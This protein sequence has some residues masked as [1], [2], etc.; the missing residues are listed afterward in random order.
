[1]ELWLNQL[2]LYEQFE[3]SLFTIA[4][5]IPSFTEDAITE[6]M[7]INSM[8]EMNIL[9]ITKIIIPISNELRGEI[10]KLLNVR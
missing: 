8:L 2:F 4:P 10:Q 3:L 5:L 7:K 9:D 6:P 1:M